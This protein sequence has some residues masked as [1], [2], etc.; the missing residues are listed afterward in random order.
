MGV[1]GRTAVVTGG[2]SGIGAGIAQSLCEQGAHV[3]ILDLDAHGAERFADAL[4]D[5][6]HTAVAITAN[7]AEEADVGAAFDAVEAALGQ[8]DILVNNAGVIDDAVDFPQMTLASWERMM[9]VNARG[10]SSC[11]PGKQPARWLRA[12]GVGSSTSPREAGWA[13][14]GSPGTAPRKARWSA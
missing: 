13:T 8:V 14:P 2:A 9:T 12:G 4:V 5:Q 3:A 11:A 1:V 10:R 6:G 7:V